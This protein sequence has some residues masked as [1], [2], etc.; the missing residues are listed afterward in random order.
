MYVYAPALEDAAA[1]L[2]M[3]WLLAYPSFF[4]VKTYD[5]SRKKKMLLHTE[6]Q[7]KF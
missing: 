4:R 1:T 7:C 5:F 3:A 6:V 2:F